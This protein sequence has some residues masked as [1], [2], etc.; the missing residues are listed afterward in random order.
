MLDADT[1]E[2]EGQQSTKSVDGEEVRREGRRDDD[3]AV[4]EMLLES[5]SRQ[6]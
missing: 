5:A 3:V 1:R 6:S 2:N 4:V